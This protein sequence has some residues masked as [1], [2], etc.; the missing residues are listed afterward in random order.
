SYVERIGE[1][2]VAIQEVEKLEDKNL[3]REYLDY[4]RQASLQA[5]TKEISTIN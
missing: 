2:T 5:K 4:K 1:N 3:N